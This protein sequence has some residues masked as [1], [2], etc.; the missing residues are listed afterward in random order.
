MSRLNELA[1]HLRASGKNDEALPMLEKLFHAAV[2]N[3]DA[4][5]DLAVACNNLATLYHACD[6]SM[7]ALPLL[8]KAVCINAKIEHGGGELTGSSDDTC[9]ALKFSCF[10]RDN[11]DAVCSKLHM[12]EELINETLITTLEMIETSSMK[13]GDAEKKRKLLLN[14]RMKVIR[15]TQERER[16]LKLAGNKWNSAYNK[17]KSAAAVAAITK[18]EGKGEDAGRTSISL[19]QKLSDAAIEKRLSARER[20]KA[21]LLSAA[22]EGPESS[23]QLRAS[24]RVSSQWIDISDISGPVKP[25]LRGPRRHTV[26]VGDSSASRE[27]RTMRSRHLESLGELDESRGPETG[28][29]GESPRRLQPLSHRAMSPMTVQWKPHKMANSDLST[30]DD[31]LLQIMPNTIEREIHKGAGIN[32]DD[33]DE[34]SSEAVSPGFTRIVKK[35]YRARLE[36]GTLPST[37]V[38]V[39]P[40][41]AEDSLLDSVLETGANEL[42]KVQ[43]GATTTG[44]GKKLKKKKIKETEVKVKA[45]KAKEVAKETETVAKEKAA[46]ETTTTHD[47]TAPISVEHFATATVGDFAKAST[48]AQDYARRLLEPLSPIGIAEQTPRN[49]E[50]EVVGGDTAGAGHVDDNPAQRIDFLAGADGFDQDAGLYVDDSTYGPVPPPSPPPPLDGPP[51][52]GRK[53]GQRDGRLC[54]PTTAPMCPS[55]GERPREIIVLPCA[56]LCACAACGLDAA[57]CLVCGDDVLQV[58]DLRQGAGPAGQ[59]GHVVGEVT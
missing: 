37:S 50:A 45:G 7:D 8:S 16:A 41:S 46:K 33:N 29:E 30:F 14:N 48:H 17:I 9:E 39:M 19:S 49:E 56:H 1:L 54:V 13:P 25:V 20:G 6:R 32:G 11:Y 23:W 57:R 40:A 24:R 10:F 52:G 36:A 35:D 44:G 21:A 51:P 34:Y 47:S 4:P 26:G 2:I 22:E 5:M 43:V 18:R 28:E 38:S 58:L 53:G 55:C 15:A 42:S 12:S 31:W 27:I 59:A 3:K